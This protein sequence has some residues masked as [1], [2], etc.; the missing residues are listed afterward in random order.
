MTIPIWHTHIIGPGFL[1]YVSLIPSAAQHASMP[2]VSVGPCAAF[3]GNALPPTTKRFGTSHDW[4]YLFT[5]LVEGSVPI[6]APPQLCVLWYG[7]ML[8]LFGTACA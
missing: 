5:T 7:T 4:R 3:C 6:T 8:Y 1:T 2:I